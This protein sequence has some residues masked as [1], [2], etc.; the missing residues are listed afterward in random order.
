MGNSAD[1]ESRF[2]TTVGAARPRRPQ[3]G[4][5]QHLTVTKFT[6]AT[7]SSY[8]TGDNRL[9]HRM[10]VGERARAAARSLA[11]TGFAT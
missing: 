1:A 9:V 5:D 10:A 3:H 11:L 8:G 7:R 6:G 4:F 2:V